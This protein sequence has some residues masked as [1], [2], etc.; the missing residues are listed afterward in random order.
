MAVNCA[1]N[2]LTAL[3]GCANGELAQ[4]PELARKVTALCNEITQV[5]Y[6]AG[7]T[8][9]AQSLPQTVTEVIKKTAA[10][11][12]S[13]LQDVSAGRQTEIDYITGYLLRTAK[14]H[15]IVAPHNTEMFE[16]IK[17]IAH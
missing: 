7:F 10:N 15:G 1:I 4:R 3:H 12:S 17:R 2:P 8:S 11:R 5:S 13:M 16:R 6:A 9:T 14:D